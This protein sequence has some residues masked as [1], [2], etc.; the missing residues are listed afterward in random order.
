MVSIDLTQSLCDSVW[1]IN[2]TETV[3][4]KIQPTL[5]NLIGSNCRMTFIASEGSVQFSFCA[6]VDNY[7][8]KPGVSLSIYTDDNQPF[9]S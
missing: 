4:V 8:N 9:V 3:R 5:F 7:I 6:G 1:T 2:A